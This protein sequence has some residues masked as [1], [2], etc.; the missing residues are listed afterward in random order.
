MD[1]D[2]SKIFDILENLKTNVNEGIQIAIKTSGLRVAST[3]KAKL[4]IYQKGIGPYPAWITLSAEAVRRK[5]LSKSKG[6]H[7]DST[8]RVAINLT[9]AGKAYL[10]K[11]GR[12][13][14]IFRSE[15]VFAASGTSDDGPLVDTGHLRAAITIDETD[16]KDN[17]VYIGVGGGKSNK[18]GDSPNVYAATHEFG[19]ASRDIP[20]RPYLRPSIFENQEEIKKDI[21][22][23]IKE[24]AEKAWKK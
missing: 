19:D 18:K 20:A 23:A 1:D 5:Y 11:Y 24:G 10:K 16:I 3:A 15:K 7:I 12:N 9:S 13:A 4:G 17:I 8:G 21:I 2:L 14:K 6:F 22:N